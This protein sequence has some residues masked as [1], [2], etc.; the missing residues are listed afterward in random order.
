MH[1]ISQITVTAQMIIENL[2]LSQL[3]KLM[4]NPSFREN[5]IHIC[6]LTRDSD[7]VA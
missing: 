7:T 1:I 3:H 4:A 2:V 6:G 5:F